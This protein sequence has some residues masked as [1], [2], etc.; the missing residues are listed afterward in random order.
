MVYLKGCGL[1]AKAIDTMSS[2]GL[3]MSQK[4]A[5]KGINALA[6]RANTAEAPDPQPQAPLLPLPRQ[7]SVPRL[8]TTDRSTESL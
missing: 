2:L 3:T 4:W 8:R 5:F 6:E 1:P 7:H